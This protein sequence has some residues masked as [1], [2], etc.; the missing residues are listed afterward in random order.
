MMHHAAWSQRIQRVPSNSP[1]A[2]NQERPNRSMQSRP[3]SAFFALSIALIAAASSAHADTIT[4]CL[5]GSCDFTDPV[6]AV[7]AAVAGDVVEIA[8][9]T[10]PVASSIIVYGKDITI[11]G[12]IGANGSPATVLSGQSART[13]IGGLVL[14]AQARF[15]NLVITNGRGDYG[16]GVSLSNASP[17]FQNCRFVNNVAV[18]LGG[19]MILNNGSRPTMIDCTISGNSVSNAQGQPQGAAGA[20]SI[21]NGALTLVGC[22][23]TGNSANYAGG[24]FLLTSSGTL[25]LESTR[26]CG[27]T[28]PNG[29]QIHLN[30]GGG[31]VNEDAPS[32]ISNDCNDCPVAPACFA[33]LDANG[34]V[35]GSDLGSLLAAWGPCA[36]CLAD[37]DGD[38]FVNG[39]DLGMMLGSW[40]ACR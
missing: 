27:N 33:D 1:C 19:A 39:R 29:T 35:D 6:A 36:D 12:A 16:G 28:A 10:Y 11:R 23:V 14:T 32:C 7:N 20:V 34:F 4:V 8:A 18:W 9:G 3:Y 5:D 24:A 21:G 13:V 22:T 15:E 2:P 37:I 30:G 26:V 40:G 38:G 17:V 31:T 25:V